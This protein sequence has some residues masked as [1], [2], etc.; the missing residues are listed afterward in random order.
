MSKYVRRQGVEHPSFTK[1]FPIHYFSQ[2]QDGIPGSIPNRKRRWLSARVCGW[3]L[4]GGVVQG[5]VPQHK[6][7]REI[8]GFLNE[9]N[10]DWQTGCLHFSSDYTVRAL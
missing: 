8:I 4:S 7:P 6:A 10:F 5:K 1:A 3:C 2:H 9:D